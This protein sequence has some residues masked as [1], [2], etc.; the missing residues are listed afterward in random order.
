[1]PHEL[2]DIDIGIVTSLQQDGRKS[3]RQIARELDISTPT[4]QARYQRL[5]N[6]GLIKSV[7]P[8]IDSTNVMDE[9]KEQ[10]NACD[11]HDSSET[12]LKSGMSVKMKCDLCDG[13]IGDKPHV[14]KF[15]NF[16]RFFC[17]NTCKTQFKEKNKGRIESIIE[18]A[19]E[20]Q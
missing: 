3:F 19:K 15:A 4:V 20:E 17:C 1:M 5:V 12:N 14:L 18:K 8:V 10:L 2:D 13:I 9:Q 11:C 7:S 16:E 6:I